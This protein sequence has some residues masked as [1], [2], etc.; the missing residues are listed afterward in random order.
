M[1]VFQITLNAKAGAVNIITAD[2][3]AHLLD[4]WLARSNCLIQKTMQFLEEM[5]F[6]T[7][8]SI[9]RQ[10]DS[11]ITVPFLLTCRGWKE[12]GDSLSL[13][14]P[15]SLTGQRLYP[16]CKKL[17]L[18]IQFLQRWRAHSR[19]REPRRSDDTTAWTLAQRDGMSAQEKQP[20]LPAPDSGG[21]SQTLCSGAER[22]RP[23]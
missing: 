4:R 14:L 2:I 9:K 18:V 21:V 17:R 3:F 15:P 5:K 11:T 10:S 19:S 1:S 20:T 12:A 16:S 7:A 23:M 8:Y 13:S 22:E 6:E